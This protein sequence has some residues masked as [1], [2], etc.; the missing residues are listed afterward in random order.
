MVFG[1]IGIEII[2]LDLVGLFK[3]NCEL[4]RIKILSINNEITVLKTK[5]TNITTSKSLLH[6]FWI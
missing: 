6:E 2:A 3:A 4:K 1:L 5:L